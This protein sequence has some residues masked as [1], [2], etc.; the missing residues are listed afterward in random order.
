MT[1]TQKDLDVTRRLLVLYRHSPAIA[2]VM[3]EVEYVAWRLGGLSTG[4]AK[5]LIWAARQNVTTAEVAGRG[6]RATRS[7]SR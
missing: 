3:G 5:R 6:R 1:L 7:R 2:A 4:R